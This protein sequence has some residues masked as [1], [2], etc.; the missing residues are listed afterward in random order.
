MRFSAILIGVIAVTTSSVMAVPLGTSE[1]HG[2]SPLQQGPDQDLVARD[3]LQAN[4]AR[5][6]TTS[7]A[8]TTGNVNFLAKR[9]KISNPFSSKK[10]KASD[11]SA[12]SGQ[13]APVQGQ[14]SSGPAG[15]G[16]S[17]GGSTGGGRP[18]PGGDRERQ[19][20]IAQLKEN[21]HYGDSPYDSE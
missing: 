5:E 21:E 4:Y 13:Q 15:G 18:G 17:A 16:A 10:K 19:A 14:G 11:S 1:A 3:I 7:D 20:R 9:V 8:G 6:L 2:D 12:K